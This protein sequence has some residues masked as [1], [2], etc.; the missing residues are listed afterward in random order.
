MKKEE[1]VKQLAEY[2]MFSAR[3]TKL[4]VERRMQQLGL[5]YRSGKSFADIQSALVKA[6]KPKNGHLKTEVELQLFVV[7]LDVY[8]LKETRKREG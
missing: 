8:T 3:L 7:Y 2:V 1:K 4:E 5:T 6:R